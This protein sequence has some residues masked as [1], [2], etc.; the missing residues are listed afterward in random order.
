METGKVYFSSKIG[1]VEVVFRKN[2]IFSIGFKSPVKTKEGSSV[3]SRSKITDEF[4][5]YFAGR[6]KKFS[7][8]YGLAGTPFQ[9]RVWKELGKIPYG[10]VF[11]YS[12]VARRIGKPTAVRA[13]ASAIARNPIAMAIPCHRVIGASGHL[14]G[15]AYGLQ[16]KAWLLKHEKSH[17]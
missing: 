9:E 11:S 3:F 13:V 10:K 17:A 14:A 2:I 4:K 5:E 15:Y 8:L 16:R 1:L 12:E 7:F 6:R